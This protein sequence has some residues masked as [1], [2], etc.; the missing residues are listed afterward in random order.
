[1]QLAAV[2]RRRRGRRVPLM[3]LAD[4]VLVARRQHRRKSVADSKKKLRLI[5]GDA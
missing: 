2:R 1:M 3:D 4:L 5:H